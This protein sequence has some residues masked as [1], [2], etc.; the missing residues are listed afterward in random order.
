M[1][2]G[3]RY[4]R[5][6]AGN[7]YTSGHH[8]IQALQSNFGESRVRPS[9]I[10]TARTLG[11]VYLVLTLIS[12]TLLLFSGMS[13]YESVCHTLSA[14]STGGFSTQAES[15]GA[16]EGF[17]IPFFIT[18]S[19]IMGAISF[20][21]YPEVLKNPKTLIRDPQVRY[22]LGLSIL[23]TALFALTLSGG[24]SGPEML[25]ILPDAVFQT[26][27]ALTGTGFSTIDIASLSDASKGFLSA[28]MCI[29]GSI[30]STT[31]GIKLFRLIVIVQLIR[32]V[33]YRFFLPREA[34][35]PLKVKS[36]VSI[37]TMFTVS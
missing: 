27:S 37:P 33:F 21:L 34:I 11:T 7:P 16:Y 20:S 23:G 2:R 3:N 18:I 15:I 35:T 32:L 12:L 30:G 6:C 13:F 29:G 24:N 17:L 31:G 1:D 22:M 14:I 36:Q 28:I 9:V 8:G 19:C 4:N 10:A 25:G 26:V 5:A